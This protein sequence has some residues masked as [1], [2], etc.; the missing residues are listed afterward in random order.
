M[1]YNNNNF[2]GKINGKQAS[3]YIKD[4]DYSIDNIPDRI[5]YVKKRLGITEEDNLQFPDEF[6]ESVFMQTSDSAYEPDSVHYVKELDMFLNVNELKKWCE[7]NDINMK[8]YLGVKDK[9]KEDGGKG[10]WN[11]TH[12]DTSNVKLILNKDNS[13]YSTSNIATVLE[14]LGS[15]ILEL[16][17]KKNNDEWIKVYNSNELFKR[18][19]KEE[20]LFTNVS[21]SL[22]EGR[23]ARE[24]KKEFAILSIPK[25]YKKQK[26]LQQLD[27][28]ELKELRKEY[29]DASI[30]KSTYFNKNLGKNCLKIEYGSEAPYSNYYDVIIK[31]K[32]KADKMKELKIERKEKGEDLTYEETRQL[33]LLRKHTKLL[34]KDMLD[35]LDMDKRPI[36]FK[37]PLKDQG[38]PTWNDFDELDK[39]HIKAL[40]QVHRDM[41]TV[42][43]QSDLICMLYDLQKVLEE[44]ELTENQRNILNLWIKGWSIDNI[45]ETLD[46]S[47]DTVRL[48]IDKIVNKIV[49][50]Y[51]SKMEDWYYLNICK[52]KYKK[53]NKCGKIK[54][55]SK[56]NKEKKGKLGVKT[57][58]K[59]CS[60][61]GSNK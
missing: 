33:R 15:Y 44:V 52:G 7:K 22:A 51:E 45:A 2:Y 61:K 26:G 34:N 20:K 40:L 28:K 11:Y 35:Y 59:K 56:F 38:C 58:C 1:E 50:I 43:F 24:N 60:N 27:N 53:C 32:D 13:L 6:W 17:K 16:D 5:E 48:S 9:F 23:N 4:L 54:L 30:K 42:D 37:Q 14:V 55:I 8:E 10:K 12:K 18:A 21:E 57:V 36:K 41:E 3:D 46:K 29:G 31:F 49:N 25:N 47:Y 39:T 19:I